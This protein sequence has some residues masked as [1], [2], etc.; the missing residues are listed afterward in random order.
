MLNSVLVMVHTCV[1]YVTVIVCTSERNVS[2]AL[3]NLSRQELEY[4]ATAS[5]AHAQ[6]FLTVLGMELASVVCVNALRYDPYLFINFF[7]E[8][9]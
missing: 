7:S 2:A 8:V 4:P 1:E 9:Q 5:A 6:M 3:V